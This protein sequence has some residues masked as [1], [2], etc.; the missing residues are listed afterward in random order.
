MTSADARLARVEALAAAFEPDD[1]ADLF[2][3]HEI[4]HLRRLGRTPGENDR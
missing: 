4:D 3:E 1:V 2:R